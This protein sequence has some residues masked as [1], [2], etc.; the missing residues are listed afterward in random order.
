[1]VEFLSISCEPSKLNQFSWSDEL[2]SGEF[3]GLSVCN[4]Y[5]EENSEPIFPQTGVSKSDVP[6]AQY[7]PQ[8]NQETLQVEIIS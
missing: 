1:M 8:P 7:N 4:L 2:Y 5:S 6:I 3:D